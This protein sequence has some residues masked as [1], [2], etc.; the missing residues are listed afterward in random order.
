MLFK[1]LCFQ[2]FLGRPYL[3]PRRGERGRYPAVIYRIP[4]TTAH[5]QIVKHHSGKR[6]TD[7]T[8]QNRF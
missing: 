8:I 5:V 3:P 6:L 7:L 4:H 2:S 1:K